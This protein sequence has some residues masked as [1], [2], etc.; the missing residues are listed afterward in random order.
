M[1]VRS[2]WLML[3]MN[4]VLARLADSAASLAPCNSSQ[5]RCAAAAVR[6]KASARTLNLSR[7]AFHSDGLGNL[8]VALAAAQLRHQIAQR[9]RYR[10]RRGQCKT[11]GQQHTA[12]RD[13]HQ[14]RRP[15]G[16]ELANRL[17]K[18]AKFQQPVSRTDSLFRQRQH[19]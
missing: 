1:G 6:L 2:S 11:K 4:S 17:S 7:R 3:A 8:A 9:L 13:F 14:Y 18:R 19:Q 10:P 5:E 16:S 15:T 12:D